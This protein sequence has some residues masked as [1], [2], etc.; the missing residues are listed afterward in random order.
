[1]SCHQTG[2][3]IATVQD[4]QAGVGQAAIGLV[5]DEGLRWRTIT[6]PPMPRAIPRRDLGGAEATN[7]RGFLE[8]FVKCEP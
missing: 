7:G 1:M 2:L 5:V 8:R 4:G 3:N 6:L